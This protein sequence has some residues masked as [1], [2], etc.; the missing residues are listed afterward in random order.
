M[1]VQDP[2]DGTRQDSRAYTDESGEGTL[3]VFVGN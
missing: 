2:E 1:T 3:L